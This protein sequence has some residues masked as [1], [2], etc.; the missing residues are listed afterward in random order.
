MAAIPKLLL[1]LWFFPGVQAGTIPGKSSQLLHHKMTKTELENFFG[2]DDLSQVPDYDI[3]EL[4]P[5]PE[6]N[7]GDRETRSIRKDDQ[8]KEKFYKMKIFDEEL[9]LKL[10]LN[11]KLVSPYMMV[12]V[13]R[14][15]GT[16]DYHPAPENNF[17]L[18]KVTSDPESMVAVRDAEGMHGVIRRS[19]ETLYVHPLPTH[20]AEHVGHRQLQK[21]HI[22][23]KR[24]MK[25]FSDQRNPSKREARSAGTS[26][27]Y[28]EV[29]LLT[30]DFTAAKYGESKISTFMLTLG[31]IV[32]GMFQD[33]SIGETKVTYVIK[34][35]AV[36]NSTKLGLKN[37]NKDSLLKIINE[38]TKNNHHLGH[39]DV[40]SYVSIL[41][42]NTGRAGLDTMCKRPHGATNINGDVGLQ[43][44]GMI[45]HETG[46][47]MGLKHDGDNQCQGG[48][49]IMSSYLPS[50]MDA[51]RWS[52]CS[53]EKIQTFLS[54]IRS[55]CL[56]NE[57]PASDVLSTP[58]PDVVLSRLPGE[59][60]DGHTQ[61]K[62]QFGK[63][64]WRWTEELSNCAVLYC[65]PDGYSRE[66]INTPVADGTACGPRDWCI[67]GKCQDN[68]RPR[69]DGGWSKWSGYT[70]CTLT[71]GGGVQYRKR[72]CTNPAP[73]YGGKSC[74]GSNIG[75]WRTCN[76]MQCVNATS[77]YRQM[78]CMAFDASFVP[79]YKKSDPCG[80]Y[81]RV[82]N[83]LH[84]KGRVKD[85][86]R[87]TK[88]MEDLD[89]CIKGKPEVVGCDHLLHSR[90]IADRCG[91][92]DGK[93]DSCTYEISS[94]T[95]KIA[96]TRESALI[97]E[98]P[99]G[100]SYAYFEK[101]A[102]KTY[103]V[104]GI[105]DVY[106]KYL[107]NV[108]YV[109]SKTITY[110]GAK[111]IYKHQS[112]KYKDVLEIRGPTNE[113]LRVVFLRVYEET[114]GVDYAIKRPLLPGE[115][116]NLSYK[117]MNM[118]D[119]SDCS[120]DCAGGVQ[121]R[122]VRCVLT[123]DRTVVSDEACDLLTKPPSSRECHMQVCAPISRWYVTNWSPC[124]KTCG[125]GSRTRNV[126]CRQEVSSTETIDVPESQC[127][128]ETKPSLASVSE[129]CNEILCPAEWIVNSSWSM[130]STSCG[131]GIMTRQ[132]VCQQTAEN[133]ITSTVSELACAYVRNKPVTEILCSVNIPCHVNAN[134]EGMICS[135]DPCQNGGTC[136]GNSVDSP[137]LC[138]TGF[139]G[140]FCEVKL[141]P[142]DSSPCA[143][144]EICTPEINSPLGYTCQERV[145][146][147]D[148]SPCYNDGTCVNDLQN[149]SKYHCQC[150]P[151]LTGSNCEVLTSACESNPCV[152]NGYCSSDLAVDPSQYKCACSAW[153]T[154]KN[155]EVQIFPC[156]SKPCLNG[157]TCSN[158]PHIISK[159]HCQCPNWFIG[160][161][162]QVAQT[163]CDVDNPCVNGGT[164]NST[165]DNPAQ[166]SCECGDWFTGKDCEVRIFPCDSKPC[167]NG[168]TCTNDDVDVS[169][170]H[171]H[172]TGGYSG[173]NCQVPSFTR[174]ACFNIGSNLLPD[175]LGDFKNLVKQGRSKESISACAELA[176]GR[177]YK[178]FALGFNGICRSGPNARQQYHIKGSTKEI[179]CPNGIGI[180]KRIAV[181]T[182]E[183]LPERNPLGCFKERKNDRVLKIKFGSFESSYNASDPKATVVKC[184]HLARDMDYEYFAVQ[185]FGDCW[186]DTKIVDSYDKYGKAL[187]EKCAGGVGAS[188][189]NFMYR[190]RPAFTGPNVCDTSPCKNGGT[191]VVHF[192]DPDRYYCECG[193]WFTGDNCGVQIYPCDG[194]PCQNGAT[195]SNDANDISKYKCQCRDWFTGVDCEVA[196]TICDTDSPCLNG[197]HCSSNTSSPTH[198]TCDC[199]DWFQSKNCEV[200][201]YPC[202]SKPCVNGATCN[203]DDQDV[204]L[205]HC[206]CTGDYS[207][208][209]CQVPSFSKIACF[210]TSSK[211][212]P[213]V[214]GDF[215]D[216]VK[217]NIFQQAI[218]ACAELAFDKSYKFFALGYHGICRSGPNARQQYHS[219]SSVSDKN[220]PNGIGIDKR[221]EVYTFELLPKRNPLGCF[222]ERKNDRLLKIKFGSFESSYNASD[223]HATVVKCAHLARDKD[224]EYFAVQDF[225][226][227]WTDTKIVD[228]YNRLGKALPEKCVG[229]VGASHT[230]FVYRLRPAFTG[231]NVCDTSPCKNGG[232][233]VVHFNDPD[234][235]YCECGDWF[236][237]ENC[238]VQ[239]YP[240]DSNPCQ[241][242][243]TCN[244]DANDISRYKCQCRDWFT[245]V[246]CEVAQ[247]ICDTDKPCLNGGYCSSNTSSPTHYTCDCGDW[248]S[249]TN[250]EVQHYPCDSKPCVNG[251]TCSN[252]KE[253]V[254]LYHCHCTDDYSGKNCQVPSFNT[255]ACFETSS[256][257]LPDVLGNFKDSVKENKIQQAISACAELAFDKSYKFFALGYHGICRSGPNARQ[258][259]HSKRSLSD[260]NCPNGIGIDKRIEVYTFE[261]LPAVN[262]LGCFLEKKNNRLLNKKFESFTS[263]YNASDPHATVVKCAHLARDMDYEYFAV[264]NLGECWTDTKIVDSYDKYGKALPG[265]CV[266]GVGASYTNF[267]YR[268]R[269]AFTGPNVCDTSP[270]K[271][272]GTCV[273]HFNDPD[274]YYCECGDWF[275]GDNCEVQI[276]PCDSNP[277]QNGA[278][279]KNDADDI[280]KYKCE[281]RD[282][283]TGINC[284]VAQTI[285][286]T[287][288]PCLN[289]GHCS[290][291][292]SSP[293]HYTCDCG[294]WFKGTNCE[295]QIYPCDSKPCINGATCSNDDQD[296]SLYHC[297]CTEGYIGKNCQVPS[298]SKI[299]CFETSS[300]LLPD[301]LGDF[302]NL[303]KD[304]KIQ[305]T[306]S[307]CAELAF[308][309][310]YKFFALG[311]H[312]ICR[313]GPNARQQYYSKRSV[314]DENCPN[315]IGIDKRIEVYTFELLPKLN[316]LGCFVEKKRKL[317][318]L[319][320]KFGSFASS[321]SPSDPHATVVKCAHLARD[322]DYEYFAVQ[323]LG[324]CWTD[325][326]IVDNYDKH[327]KAL[328]QN[329]VGGVG[330]SYTNFVYRRRPESSVQ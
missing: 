290:S 110:A 126:I 70:P 89:V 285:C 151:W 24:S 80:L 160:D 15:D 14:G 123:S 91:V 260:K 177:S 274:R 224:Y 72:T 98:L 179:N 288:N 329:C 283:F 318:L 141:N 218:S 156:D 28:L 243:A 81:C 149:V 78:Q 190:L 182:F 111:I 22:V 254:S 37:L 171:C 16:T 45:A 269:P 278:T 62:H 94:F 34:R 39:A 315:G 103:N 122:D 23:V 125:R 164:C 13:Q 104:I 163:I 117:W 49:Y 302:R 197:G 83:L 328:P 245:G 310:S 1:I 232:T 291:N 178:F 236:I 289:G 213:D 140:S 154:G 75:H 96:N 134:I 142:C 19:A 172:C 210:D 174:I 59:I 297:H 35:V 323:N 258:Q 136:N 4:Y 187:P 119:W 90:K 256:S 44:A 238:D 131:A 48:R 330:A 212:L 191:C 17:Y 277:C 270:C 279:C 207:G 327:G 314:S 77:T 106:G 112:T 203:N 298:F 319:N 63:S 305:Q 133:G 40:S 309:K 286:D 2:S 135:P 247:T 51:M 234:R 101:R 105:Q 9:P 43:T 206:H 300:K 184:A 307:A 292:T 312:G 113:A 169:L 115:S 299:A 114:Q 85:G 153:F 303:V 50:G 26:N 33:V 325:K 192:N 144:E 147:C 25:S 235:Y 61:C 148:S 216:L 324:D 311:Y 253:D 3:T 308:D 255:I 27:K 129:V 183:L 102:R 266:G 249:G 267:M 195:C 231:P 240:C 226:D 139:T 79:F 262:P 65:T 56:D 228:N 165:S 242:G 248:F 18:G 88:T 6:E 74:Q 29:A 100:T 7:K 93:A 189:T 60:V 161:R 214:L 145:Y 250:C 244:N 116:L 21:P 295:V 317:R 246:N 47:N 57:P 76:F 162:C 87:V 296:V 32:A 219:K 82:G 73:K 281:C 31:N 95:G 71:C 58:S 5:S 152:N 54:S 41:L 204:S 20:L 313:S 10:S 155:C 221:I 107:I 223:P 280:S 217:D 159:Y 38:W 293:T 11:D 36:L 205:Y 282:W 175:V 229:G 8:S 181:F 200:Q 99:P 321:Y 306:I 294:D 108:P 326:E 30:D 168:G 199:G 137:C 202:D 259:Y 121:E 185:D 209:N 55:T 257:L 215:R 170:Y 118:T 252:D 211:L 220:C 146:P 301:V 176:F 69:V 193:D 132:V 127:S 173:K 143:K 53:Q 225:A 128:A 188:Y 208:K 227:C 67:K 150:R 186:T 268:L 263:S 42:G 196:Q 201:I 272:G 222:R 109:Y 52:T 316:T 287:D 251:A 304:N 124:S 284:E 275:I 12:E 138:L 64:Y 167:V 46:H 264:Q 276:Y 92:C 68:G 230:N 237:G 273:V 84:E 86:T 130:C 239:I 97:T 322:M 120:K 158:D 194:S 198:Y 180:D 265:K 66:S 320:I 157:G 166:Y 271:N 261:L 241:N 233:C